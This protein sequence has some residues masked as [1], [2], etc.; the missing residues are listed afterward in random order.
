MRGNVS[1]QFVLNSKKVD[2]CIW[3]CDNLYTH[4]TSSCFYICYKLHSLHQFTSVLVYQNWTNIKQCQR[5]LKLIKIVL[6]FFKRN[7]ITS[8]T[9]HHNIITLKKVNQIK[10][11]VRFVLLI[12]AHIVHAYYIKFI[13]SMKSIWT[14]WY[15]QVILF[16]LHIHVLYNCC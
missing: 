5:E 10:F 13:T 16:F 4:H 2:S 14:K 15:I 8:Y 3:S 11:C 1:S 6:C 12:V 7:C 9:C